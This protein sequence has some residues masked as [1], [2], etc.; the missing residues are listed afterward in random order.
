MCTAVK[1]QSTPPVTAAHA[2]VR[3]LPAAL[4]CA[5]HH[6]GENGL[7]PPALGAVIPDIVCVA[8]LEA[9]SEGPTVE[10]LNKNSY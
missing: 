8:P 6:D 3:R 10:H 5:R 2:L 1:V 4:K 7:S 9:L